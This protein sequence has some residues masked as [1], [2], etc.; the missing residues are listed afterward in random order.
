MF[1]S[2]TLQ[3]LR[4]AD[5]RLAAC[6]ALVGFDGFVDLIVTPV[7]LR[8]SQGEDF[9]AITTIGEFGQR[10]L[11]AAG[12]STNIELF[13]RAEKLGGNGP[14]M[15]N[16][17]LAAGAGVTYIG[18]LG[19]PQVHPVFASMAARARTI[20]LCDAA[21]TTALEFT[22]GK[23]LLGTMRS[24]DEVTFARILEVMG[25]QA[26]QAE[27]A[28]ASIVA[29]VNWTMIPNM[30]AIL[31]ELTRSVLPKIPAA[32]NRIFFFD[33]ADPEKRSVGDLR[34]A[35]A[36][37]TKFEAFGH[38]TLGLNLKEGQQVGAALGCPAVAEDPDGLQDAAAAI[39]ARLGVSTVV[40]HPRE[41]AACANAAGTCWVPGP[42][43]ETPKLTT[44]AGDHFN[45]GFTSGQLLGLE[46]EACLTL[47]VCFSGHY[48]R[49]GESP[50]LPTIET[51][52]ANW[53]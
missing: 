9:T 1:R 8:R 23:L 28:Q 32:P 45:A 44:G 49:T 10:V 52:L 15:A 36:E 19:M 48:V 16:A 42:V 7:G 43:T 24:L 33:L 22:D 14:I 30:T 39:R 21:H 20:S 5:D 3:V 18:A 41:S 37:I 6:R 25:G 47:G 34:A 51:F 4:T 35:L 29:L 31:A 50:S 11:A 40:I 17:L 2:R 26:L 13:P 38:V 27:L 12:K 46:P 53:R